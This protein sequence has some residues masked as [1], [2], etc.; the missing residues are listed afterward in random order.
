MMPWP[1]ISVPPI[2]TE[3]PRTLLVY[4]RDVA[5]QY[6]KDQLTLPSL[7][8]QTSQGFRCGASSACA[9]NFTQLA[10]IALMNF[11]KINFKLYMCHSAQSSDTAVL[12]GPVRS[13]L[14][15]LPTDLSIYTSTS[16]ARV[17]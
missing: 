2:R 5:H 1:G 12:I 9:I 17:S 11:N 8:I 3:L 16:I 7:S 14:P 15:D 4:T 13:D 6:S 10:V